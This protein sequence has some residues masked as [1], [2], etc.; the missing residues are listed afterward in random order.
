MSAYLDSTIGGEIK[1]STNALVTPLLGEGIT[2]HM[3]LM[4]GLIAM[5]FALFLTCGM[6][7]TTI[8]NNV[9]SVV[10]IVAIVIIIVVGAYFSDLNNWKNV[11][12]GINNNCYC[13][14]LNQSQ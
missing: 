10:N 7:V 8:A 9:F 6:R 2:S 14:R 5:A 13:N 1:N 4:S 12:G 3:D 11:P